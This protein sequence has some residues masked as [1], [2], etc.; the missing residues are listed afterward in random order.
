M[1]DR[2]E[3]HLTA[4]G[5]ITLDENRILIEGFGAQNGTC[6]DV[7]ALALV[8]AIGRLQRELMATLEKPGGG[9]AIVN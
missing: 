4:T 6:R 7:A 9:I 5:T 3:A 1:L 2:E 8:W